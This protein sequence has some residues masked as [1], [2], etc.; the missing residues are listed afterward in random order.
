[1]GDCPNCGAKV[2]SSDKRCSKCGTEIKGNSSKLIIGIVI[3]I[4]VIAIGGIFASGFFGGGDS[5]NVAVANDTSTQDNSATVNQSAADSNS[6]ESAG[7]DQTNS[8]DVK[9]SGGGE[10]WAS[11]K[12]DKFHSPDCEWAQK[13]KSSNK[14]VFD[15]RE[16]A[17]AS[18]RE[19]CSVCNP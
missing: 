7:N 16:D 10:Y 4:V 1:M 14:I 3:A 6:N 13:I 15:S 2:S 17:L 9:S 18:G 5:S 19:P 12:T 11:A 8:N